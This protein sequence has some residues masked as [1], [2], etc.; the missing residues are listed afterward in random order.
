MKIP[1]PICGGVNVRFTCGDCWNKE[2]FGLKRNDLVD[3]EGFFDVDKV[4][5]HIQFII[6]KKKLERI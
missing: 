1:C 3:E 5:A 6:R 2:E 4:N